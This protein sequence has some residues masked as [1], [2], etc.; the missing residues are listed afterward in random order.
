MS[1]QKIKGEREAEKLRRRLGANGSYA[2]FWSA[3][4]ATA[5]IMEEPELIA[6]VCKGLYIDTAK[7]CGSSPERVER[8]IRTL[9]ERI[10]FDGDRELLAEIYGEKAL[11]GRA[12]TNRVF[13]DMLAAYLREK[14]DETAKP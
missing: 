3:A 5:R 9:K 4:Y 10:W 8:N 12:P 1:R 14:M 6:Y 7:N 11:K 13:L 2:G